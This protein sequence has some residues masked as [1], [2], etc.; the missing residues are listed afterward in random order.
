MKRILVLVTSLDRGGIEQM[1]MNYYRV[2]DRRKFQFDFL[3]N[4]KEKGVFEDE[5]VRLGGRIFRM[6]ELYP[7]KFGQYK[8]ELKEFLLAH[9]EYEMIHSHLEERS[10]LA[11]KVA[12]EMGVPVR[13]AHAHNV[14]PLSLN[15]KT[16][17]RQYFRYKVREVATERFS[18]SRH[19]AMWLFGEEARWTFIPNAISPERF[20]FNS[21]KREVSRKKYGI[22]PES[23]VLG[24]VGRMTAQKNPEFAIKVFY[25]YK[26]LSP[27][28]R[29]F[30]VGKGDLTEVLREKY[31]EVDF[32]SPVENIED[33]YL[34]FDIFLLPS[35]Y[36]GLGMVAIE[37]GASGLAVLAS[38]EVPKEA[39]VLNN[40]EFVPADD[41]ARWARIIEE[42]DLTRQKVSSKSFGEYDIAVAVK[43]LEK[44]Y[45]NLAHL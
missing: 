45:E 14:Y 28:A 33:F 29:L 34:M 19:A 38:T 22:S 17:F 23:V 2:M 15:P 6:C 10:Y 42:K 43:K 40:V 30:M 27:Q 7:W 20:R 18:C 32:I 24:F 31:H 36:E 39:N 44:I 25:E 37:A 35:R 5:I 4:R 41:S 1:I 21:D 9:P 8:R 16:I 26:K 3:V 13:I 11:L 12:K